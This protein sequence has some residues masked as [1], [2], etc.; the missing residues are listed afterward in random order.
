MGEDRRK[1]TQTLAQIDREERDR[2]KKERERERGTIIVEREKNNI[3]NKIDR[4]RDI[5]EKERI[6]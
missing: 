3:V 1:Q 2:Y 5:L 4:K 6:F